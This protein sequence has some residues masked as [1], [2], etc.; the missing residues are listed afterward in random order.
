METDLSFLEF[1]RRQKLRPSKR[2]NKANGDWEAAFLNG[3]F[4]PAAMPEGIF[5]V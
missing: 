1:Y 5:D 2:M 4:G 3:M